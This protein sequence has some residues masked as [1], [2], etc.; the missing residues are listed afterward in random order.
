MPTPAPA[1]RPSLADAAWSRLH[2][3][4]ERHRG[5]VRAAPVLL[6]I[7]IVCRIPALTSFSLTIDDELTAWR[8]DP[9]VW[10]A[11]GRWAN[12]LLEKFVVDQPCVPFFMDLVFC[13]SA[14]IA[15]LLLLH[16]HRLPMGPLAFVAFPLF[17][18]S[19]QWDLIGEFYGNL[20]GVA[21]ALVC[22]ALAGCLFRDSFVRRRASDDRPGWLGI[23]AQVLLVATATG[24]YQTFLF[25]FAAVGCGV[26]LRTQLS[27]RPP[28]CGAAVRQVAALAAVTI[29]AA[30]IHWATAA[31]LMWWLGART[32]YVGTFFTLQPLLYAPLAVLARSLQSIRR[33]LL[34]SASTYGIAI[35]GAAILM[36]AGW[37]ALLTSD[38]TW[39]P[40]VRKWLC[41]GLAAGCC[42]APFALHPLAAG[43]L[44]QRAMM[45][46][47]YVAWLFAVLP[48]L[49][50]RKGWRFVAA[51]GLVIATAQVLY[52]ASASAASRTLT[53]AHDRQ[54]AAEVYRR[55][56]AAHP[57]FSLDRVYPVALFGEK[58][59]TALP[60]QLG[61][62]STSAGSFFQWDGGSSRRCVAFMRLLGYANLEPVPPANEPRFRD[63]AA[64][65]PAWPAADSV[66]VVDGVTVI[67][68]G[69]MRVAP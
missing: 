19:P 17:C 13:A 30:I 61:F 35:W 41:V 32:T 65:M 20:T 39:K 53:A 3:F 67:K 7:A 49:L 43:W 31:A 27:P 29:A 5:A 4:V 60:Y 12:W 37:G 46:I 68:M 9:L 69:P 42:L 52:L 26:V 18:A 51:A 44:P 45:A 54:F 1:E 64:T 6:L 63:E 50:P 10:A 62:G 25:M 40:T 57:D 66:K 33:T 8:D 36:V 22:V 38:G 23:A 47:P 24:C 14:S 16:A 48:H 28:S 56:V 59:S 55:L 34:G 2:R 21:S 15:Y 11:E 58:P